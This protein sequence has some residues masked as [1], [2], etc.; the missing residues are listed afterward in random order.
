[1]PLILSKITEQDLPAFTHI[2]NAAFNNGMASKLVPK[3]ITPEKFAAQVDKHRQSFLND[4]DVTHLKVIDTDI[5]PSEETGQMIACAKWR[6]NLK[7]RTEEEVEA[8]LPKP[9]VGEAAQEGGRGLAEKEFVTYLANSR[10]KWMG[11][12]AFYFLHLLVTLPQHHR[13]G[14]GTLLLKW[15]LDQADAAGLPTYLEASEM[16]RPLYARLGFEPKKETHFD[17]GRYGS[18]GVEI[19]TAMVRPVTA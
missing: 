12:R 18:E 14:A 10:R 6:I 1:M 7:E 19:N 11:A 15:G 16:G 3:P 17:L 8:S 9:P 2:C 4:E 5:E 13:R